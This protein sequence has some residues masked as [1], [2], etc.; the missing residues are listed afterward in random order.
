MEQPVQKESFN[1]LSFKTIKYFMISTD[2]GDSNGMFLAEDHM[3][4][5]SRKS[6]VIQNR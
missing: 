3:T 4:K 2:F 1:K 6:T 5:V